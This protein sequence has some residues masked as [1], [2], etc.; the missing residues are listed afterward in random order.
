MSQVKSYGA[1]DMFNFW[2]RSQRKKKPYL[3][4][5]SPGRFK[6]TEL[7]YD[8][9]SEWDYLKRINLELDIQLQKLEQED[10]NIYYFTSITE[11]VYELK[12]EIY[13]NQEK[14]DNLSKEDPSKKIK[15]LDYE[16]FKK[17]IYK[18]NKLAVDQ[19]IEGEVPNLNEKLGYLYILKVNRLNK[20]VDWEESKKF[21]LELLDQGK[22]PKDKDHPEGEN[23]LVYFESNYYLMWNWQKKFERTS[24]VRNCTVYG[25]YPTTTS[26]KGI[27]GTK[28]LL[29]EANKQNP[30]LHLKYITT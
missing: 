22:T 21:K 25:F 13:N 5:K 9:L 1:R 12:K 3:I 28:K 27:P 4:L 10:T 16:T 20:A 18:Y 19:L 14:I 29:V 23:W 17:V 24:R 30:A 15:L 6:N 26:G 7:W 8:V 2:V 11:K